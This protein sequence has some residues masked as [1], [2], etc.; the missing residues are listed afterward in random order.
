MGQR[1]QLFVIAKI[2]GRYRNLAN[3][4]HQWLY[5]AT[6]LKRCY[7]LV[8]IFQA[9]E[10]RIPIQQEL[11][12]AWNRG[13]DSWKDE[14][15]RRENKAIIPFPMVTTCLVLGTSFD[16]ADG[17][18]SNVDIE[19]FGMDYNGSDNNNGITVIDISELQ[20]VRYCFVDILPWGM[21]SETP[22]P[23]MTPLSA[24][25]YLWSYYDEHD[26]KYQ[27]MFRDLVDRLE[28]WD[29]VDIAALRDTWPAWR[30]PT[31][32]DLEEEEL[33][34][35]EG[36]GR[37]GES[38]DEEGAVEE[39]NSGEGEGSRERELGQDAES[40]G[41]TRIAQADDL[42]GIESDTDSS[43]VQS[44]VQSVGLLSDHQSTGLDPVQKELS[45][46][47][48][49]NLS[50]IESA[51]LSSSRATS[52]TPDGHN[53]LRDSAM[54]TMLETALKQSEA[55]LRLWIP[56]A[57]LLS[58]FLPSLKRKL[59]QDPTLLKTS[60]AGQFLVL[61]VL[62][63][64]SDIDIALLKESTIE[65]I[66]TVVSKL[67][68]NGQMRSISI[69]NMPDLREEDLEKVFVAGTALESIYVLITPHISVKSIVSFV[70]N[71]NTA[72][73]NLYHTELLRRPLKLGLKRW[74]RQD[75][76]RFSANLTSQ[77]IWVKPD[78]VLL[79]KDGMR[80]EDGQINWKA[81]WGNTLAHG[82]DYSDFAYGVF[83]LIDILLP[84]VKIVT[85]LLHFLNWASL[86]EGSMQ[87]IAGYG[88]GLANSFAMAKSS[89]H[90]S[91][92]Q[93]GPLSSAL[94]A[95]RTKRYP[96][97]WPW[98]TAS[99]TPGEWSIV[100]VHEAF[101]HPYEASKHPEISVKLRCAMVTT[102]DSSSHDL[103]VVDMSTFLRQV[104][105]VGDTVGPNIQELQDYWIQHCKNILSSGEAVESSDEAEIRALLQTVFLPEN[106]KLR[107]RDPYRDYYSSNSDGER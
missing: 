25:T 67:S 54:R 4:Y 47:R 37:E 31:D 15:E 97:Q 49:T 30:D 87:G 76:I 52:Q 18:L 12:S 59:Y 36:S 98:K 34:E 92:V 66:S 99:L 107:T 73:Q 1:H 55:D 19:P 74:L 2:N 42:K 85:G 101:D 84:P 14:E 46:G 40:V 62:K 9:V 60:P 17:Y 78:A 53:T 71:H 43:T 77:I 6:A 23:L 56:E 72:L 7:K 50:I 91:D 63:D 79:S 20:H 83:P 26:Q 80:L 61:K 65:E 64:E 48:L 88:I 3:V 89:I 94:Y 16:A 86:H 27:D 24:S 93:V 51:I 105:K 45:T 90:G 57:E 32:D 39:E 41:I 96:S 68:K 29:L 38:G 106:D 70:N 33:E 28:K 95:T 35:G 69:S 21:E 81:V 10:N 58:D 100:I 102:R 44:N 104:M 13:E 75:K 22:V 8:Q 103:E 82:I 11:L 5:G